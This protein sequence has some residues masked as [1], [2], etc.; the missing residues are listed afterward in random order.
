MDD[1]SHLH[2]HTTY[3]MLDGAIRIPDLMKRVKELGMS[4]VAITDHG[5]MYGAIEFYK[6]AI[7]HDVKPIIG[8]EFYVTPSRS[9]ETELDEIADGGAYHIIL[10]CKNELGYKNMIKLAS[11]SFT[12]G[13]Y[14]KPR[15]DYDLLERHSE[16]LVCLTACLAGEVNRKILEGKEDK[17]FALAG[18]LHEI[19]RKED[20]YLEIQDHGIPE[21]RTVAEAVMGFSKR[22][23][24]PLVLTNDS[25]FLTKD[26]REA[27]DI[28]L[29][30]GMRKNIDDEMRFGFNQNFYVKSPKEMFSI[31]PDH[32][33]AFYNTLAIRDKCSLN[34][35]FGNPLLP[36]FDVPTGYDTDSYL[37]KLVWDG[38]NEKYPEITQVIKDRTEFEMQTIRNMHFAGYFLIVQDYINF[39]RHT[40]IP[41]GPGRGS[42][43][44]SIIAYA[45]G[46]TNVDPIRYN[47]LFERFLNPDRKDMPDIDTDFCVERREEVINYIKQKYGENR[48]G[49]IITFGS[50]AAKAAIKDVARVFNVPFSE[51]N[52]MSKL[53]PKKLGITIQEALDTSKDLKDLAEKSDLNKKV[54]LI[55]QKLE[56][57]YRQVG[58]HAA[59]V[60]IAP[61]PLE[62]IVPLSTVS[63]AGREGRSIVTQF[64]K[65][66]SE[67]VGLIKMDILGLKN[68]TTIHHAVQL[69]KKRHGIL[70]DLDKIPLDD[71][72]TFSLLRKA[73][74]LGIFQLDSSTGIRDLFAK[75]QVQK[76]EEIAALLALYRPG[77][78]GSGMLDDYLDR[79][80]GKKKVQFPHESLAQVLE[81]TYGVIVYQ[82]QVMGISRI[83]G[84]FSVGDSDVL[85]KAMAK[86]DKSKLPALKEKF[87]K[88]AA[89]N[90]IGEKL[91]TELFETLEKFGEYGFN[92]SHSVAYAFV[93]YQTAYLKANYAIE[94]LTA[95]LSGDH[96]KISD[97]VKY[98]NNAKE[99]GIR[100][101][102][103]DL[104]ESGLSFEIT[105][106]QT[107]RFG[108]SSLK[109]VGELAAE[110][111]L[112][113]RRKLKGYKNIEEFALHLDTRLANKKVMEALAQGGAFDSFGYARKCIFESTDSILSYAQKKQS[114]EKEGQFSLFGGATGVDDGYAL[115]LPKD[116]IEWDLD[117]LL[118]K[119]KETTGLYLSGH[120][121]DKFTEQLKSL[122]PIH[123]ED[124]E[125]V[126]P[127]SKVEIAGVLS[128]KMI[129]LTKKK[130]EFINFM[131]EDQTGEIECVAFP[132][133]YADFKPLFLEDKTLFIK[134]ILERVDVEE[135]ELKGQI[136]VNHVEELNQITIEKKMEKALHLT[137]DMSEDKNRDII[138]KIQDLFSVHRGSSAVFFHLVGTG[139]EK[140]VIKAHDHFSIEITSEL[141]EILSEMLGS[142]TVRYTIGEEVR[143]HA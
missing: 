46:I 107:I 128:K 15:I 21:Q 30:I 100:I 40:G 20:F 7:K 32:Q 72:K 52:E 48:V 60:V 122:K 119:E 93:T 73:N 116:G 133:T 84:G 43:A 143:V 65:N 110:N 18:K 44:G 56:G 16:G 74:V 117:T 25:H 139:E 129:K 23:G 35:Q 111:I 47:L 58:R 88:G 67:Q 82:E 75:A 138:L 28:L 24:I 85:R 130:E 5:N 62:E 45:L 104:I 69:I 132:R 79:K 61:S 120:P 71:Q 135:S 17:A 34:F 53:F 9:A 123:I 95:L 90:K 96:S 11:R 112:S 121:L 68:L 92:K 77:P 14:R 142:G 78:M 29:R 50:L 66:M 39:A 99:M 101:L 4:S 115:N 102:G 37:E 19:F 98:I 33:E 134:G 41:V 103:P 127:K 94:Y 137:I 136:L 125:D 13:F 27:Q 70:L 109:G 22:T 64:D 87:V 12:E 80:N 89:E 59:G 83:M 141:M 86:K 8:C 3:S 57:N 55:A 106:D 81:E 63:E 36:P 97:V 6:E 131:I 51:V 26:D 108:L 91:A 126:R 1:F 105:D 42:A 38:I 31:F 2:L 140:K 113:N 54:F 118:K 124:L 49:Q 10:L 114:E 76:F